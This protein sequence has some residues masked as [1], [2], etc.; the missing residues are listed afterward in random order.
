[1]KDK[2]TQEHDEVINYTKEKGITFLRKISEDGL[3]YD[4]IEY[5][6][7]DKGETLVF[8][9]GK[10]FDHHEVDVLLGREGQNGVR[11]WDDMW[12][13]LTNPIEK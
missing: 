13:H 6:K 5:T 11:L 10:R 4:I 8:R 1:M 3:R 7:K 2:R 12:Q 9:F